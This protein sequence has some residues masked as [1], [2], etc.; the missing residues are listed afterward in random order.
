MKT[1]LERL[2]SFRTWNFHPSNKLTPPRLA[3]LGFFLEEGNIRC[4]NCAFALSA[5]DTGDMDSLVRRHQE[6]SPAC[7]PEIDNVSV[8]SPLLP[9]CDLVKRF[10]TNSSY[11]TE[12]DTLAIDSTDHHISPTVPQ[13]FDAHNTKEIIEILKNS[14]HRARNRGLFGSDSATFRKDFDRKN[15]DYAALQNEMT[16]LWTFYDWP[17][18]VPAKPD[19]LA[20]AGFFYAGD[21]DIVRC[22][23]CKGCLRNWVPEDVPIEEH[24]KHFPDCSFVRNAEIVIFWESSR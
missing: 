14:Y 24:R 2:G 20:K 8:N 23:F 11:S 18:D 13:N 17:A 21:I 19:V 12:S 16:R 22:A 7:S 1:E 15:P 9:P 3:R 10:E 4:M 5:I 6:A